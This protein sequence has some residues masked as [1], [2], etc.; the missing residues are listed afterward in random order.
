M[1]CPAVFSFRLFRPRRRALGG[2]SV[3][4]D[5]EL[6]SN[7]MPLLDDVRIVGVVAG[8]FPDCSVLGVHIW[9]DAL[10]ASLVPSGP[11][12]R[13]VNGRI[14]R[15]SAQL[16]SSRWQLRPPLKTHGDMQ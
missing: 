6:P 1:T 2:Y 9:L 14:Y 8:G 12:H 15:E 11:R 13:V 16:G 5:L 4:E 10:G 3:S 7:P